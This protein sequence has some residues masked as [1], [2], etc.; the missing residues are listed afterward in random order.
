MAKIIYPIRVTKEER[1]I[2]S[3][4]L[5]RLKRKMKQP[6]SEIIIKALRNQ[7]KSFYANSV[8]KNN[9]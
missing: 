6:T 4:N 9:I 3:S 2:I 8:L 7:L 5:F 1:D